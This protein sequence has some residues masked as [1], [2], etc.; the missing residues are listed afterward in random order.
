MRI[1]ETKQ[2]WWYISADGF[3][4]LSLQWTEGRTSVWLHYDRLTGEMTAESSNHNLPEVK[5]ESGVEL[6]QWSLGA[7]TFKVETDVEPENWS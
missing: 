1:D 7:P 5:V 2:G 4:L 6:H 3:Y